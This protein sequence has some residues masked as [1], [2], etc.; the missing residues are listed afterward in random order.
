MVRE[1]KFGTHESYGKDI[2]NENNE[3]GFV[4]EPM[5]NATPIFPKNRKAQDLLND[6]MKVGETFLKLNQDF[7]AT[8]NMHLEDN[9]Q[10]TDHEGEPPFQIMKVSKYPEDIVDDFKAG[11]SLLDNDIEAIT[12]SP[13]GTI[14]K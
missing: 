10:S 11:P 4:I 12:T 7:G 9:I 13:T 5:I 1:E 3:K 2:R 6:V 14:V 8:S